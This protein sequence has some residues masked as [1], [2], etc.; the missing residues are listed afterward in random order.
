MV[1]LYR[2]I[3]L[4]S[5]GIHI[6]KLLCNHV[7]TWPQCILLNNPNLSSSYLLDK[8]YI[9]IILL[10]NNYMPTI[11]ISNI[12]YSRGKETCSWPVK[13]FCNLKVT[14]RVSCRT[15]GN[16]LSILS[17]NFTISTSKNVIK[18]C[19]LV[20]P[21]FFSPL[22]FVFILLIN[23]LLNRLHNC[24]NCVLITLVKFASKRKFYSG[25][26]LIMLNIINPD[27]GQFISRF[28]IYYFFAN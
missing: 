10:F 2:E 12:H 22:F 19:H 15:P 3:S 4:T 28:A 16:V 20:F 26:W 5:Y 6:H 24:K 11:S 18:L 21:F 14:S 1:C 23:L 25:P 9:P 27:V 17:N 8:F 13:N 7:Y